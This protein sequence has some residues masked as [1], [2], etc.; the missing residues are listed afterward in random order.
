MP[1]SLTDFASPHPQ[2]LYPEPETFNPDRFIDA[3]GKLIGNK[4]SDRGHF[5]YGFGRR[6]VS[7]SSFLR[8]TAG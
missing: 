2:E 6:S 5:A 3:D 1:N 7:P 8:L 4:Y